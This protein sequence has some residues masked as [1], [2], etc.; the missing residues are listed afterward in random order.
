MNEIDMKINYQSVVFVFC[1]DWMPILLQLM[2][3]SADDEAED[4]LSRQ[5]SR[6]KLVAG[7]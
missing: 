7:S 1:G 6:K 4:L 5:K 3:R 2:P